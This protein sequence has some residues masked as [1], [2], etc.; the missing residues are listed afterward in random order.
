M[1]LEA[2]LLGLLIW[3][4]LFGAKPKFALK[5]RTIKI[6]I[7]LTLFLIFFAAMIEVQ[8]GLMACVNQ[9]LANYASY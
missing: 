6:C 1:Y 4:I 2:F 5:K 9:I 8:L 3:L 7:V